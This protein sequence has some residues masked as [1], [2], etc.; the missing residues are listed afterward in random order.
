MWANRPAREGDEM[1]VNK[2]E[3]NI[4][5]SVS[6]AEITKLR[7]CI[8]SLAYQFSYRGYGPVLLTGGLSSL[9]DAFAVLGWT[10]P[11][12]AP[13]IACDESGCMDEATCGWPSEK[14]YRR[15][16]GKHMR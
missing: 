12:P 13:E 2:L 11:H 15:T 4:T 7:E 10:D 9:E 16:C 1:S 8:R 5:D 6:Q 14:G 3:L